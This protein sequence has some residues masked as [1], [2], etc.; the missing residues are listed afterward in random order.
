MTKLDEH[1]IKEDIFTSR[2]MSTKSFP[3]D[4]GDEKK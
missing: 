1:G 2:R 4:D 3:N